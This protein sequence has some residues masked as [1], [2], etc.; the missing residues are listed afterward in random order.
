VRATA[1]AEASAAINR[2]SPSELVLLRIS[3]EHELAKA[4]QLALDFRW[5]WRVI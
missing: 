1:L 3:A 2:R 5:Y 4:L